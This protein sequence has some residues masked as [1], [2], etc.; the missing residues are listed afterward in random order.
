[1]AEDSFK[2]NFVMQTKVSIRLVA[3]FLIAVLPNTSVASK[4][5]IYPVGY[6]QFVMTPENKAA[7]SAPT[8]KRCLR[9]ALRT[10]NNLRLQISCNQAMSVRLKARLEA[11]LRRT[12][13]EQGASSAIGLRES[14]SRWQATHVTAC[15][16]KWREELNPSSTSYSLAVSQCV[17]EEIYRRALWIE[18]LSR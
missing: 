14:Q 7:M 3:L 17:S 8:D 13:Q 6:D 16:T 2:G 18:G 1:M 15:E 4:L 9:Q 11:A 10:P 5:P 12:S